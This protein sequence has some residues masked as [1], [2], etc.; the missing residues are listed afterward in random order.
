MVRNRYRNQL[1]QAVPSPSGSPPLRLRPVLPPARECGPSGQRR[2]LLWRERRKT[3]PTARPPP[4]FAAP[5]AL[6]LEELSR[7]PRPSPLRAHIFPDTLARWRLIRAGFN[8]RFYAI[9]P[10]WQCHNPL[11]A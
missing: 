7:E 6:P 4:E 9:S 5:A 1:L 3:L 8:A 11:L 2:P 10:S